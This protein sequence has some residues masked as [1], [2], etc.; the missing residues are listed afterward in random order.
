VAV[1]RSRTDAEGRFHFESLGDSALIVFDDGTGPAAMEPAGSGA[2]TVRVP[3]ESSVS[4]RLRDPEGAPPKGAIVS[5]R[6]LSSEAPTRVVSRQGL[7]APDGTVQVKGLS[8]LPDRTIVEIS[9]PE[10]AFSRI[11]LERPLGEHEDLGSVELPPIAVA[12]GSV[13]SAS[14]APVAGATVTAKASR[15]PVATSDAKGGFSL[16]VPADG[17]LV[18]RVD[19]PGFLPEE[20]TFSADRPVK[21]VLKERARVLAK[22]RSSDGAIPERA[23]LVAVTYGYLEGASVSSEPGADGRFTFEVKPGDDELRLDADGAEGVLLGPLHLSSGDVVDLGTIA[24]S[25]GAILTGRL[26]DAET[27]LPLVGVTVTAQTVSDRDLYDLV[28][29]KLPGAR[30]DM[31]GAFRVSGLPEGATRLFL[32]AAGR[33][34]VRVD[35]DAT[36]EGVDLGEIRIGPG[37]P[38]ELRVL[39]G[40]GTPLTDTRVGVRPGGLDGILKETLLRTDASGRCRLDRVAPGRVGLVADTPSRQHRRTADLSE[41][42]GVVDWTTQGATVRGVVFGADGKPLENARVEL[43]IPGGGELRML[44]LSRSTN[45]GVPLGRV[46]LGETSAGGLAVTDR[47]GRFDIADVPE[48]AATLLVS[49]GAAVGTWQ[50]VV[51]PGKGEVVHDLVLAGEPLAVSL[52]RDEDGAP[53]EGWIRL[54]GL[55][56][57]ELSRSQSQ[58]GSTFLLPAASTPIG[59]TATDGTGRSGTAFPSAGARAVEVRLGAPMAELA[60]AVRDSSGRPAAAARVGLLRS[61]DSLP[62][63]GVTDIAGRWRRG[64]IAAGRYR[65]LVRGRGAESARLELDVPASLTQV[66]VDLKPTGSL[67]L[68]V[69]TDEAFDPRKSSVSVIDSR[70][71]DRAMEQAPFGRPARL[72]SAGRYRIAA[73]EAGRYSV[74]VGLGTGVLSDHELSVVIEDGRTTEKRVKGR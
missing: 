6:Q 58:G 38:L 63:S 37:H 43:A 54:T 46:T 1:A 53:R 70:G 10:G 71:A 30:T 64:P 16:P 3:P 4:L 35:A 48:G 39:R 51:V 8:A 26:V 27:G 74:R 20:A 60:F 52:V 32:E 7:P 61:A 34:V 55:G 15:R 65:V 25:S 66:P 59:V 23:R 14:G 9:T 22:L 50:P 21:I 47:D 5:V 19:A 18:A 36:T 45:D 42:D 62:L 69:E 17:K 56:G 57:K 28:R 73:L 72:D 11:V 33:P 31:A 29:E 2:V 41:G 44:D 13:A 24:L 40:D 12:R 68:L 67:S 49:A